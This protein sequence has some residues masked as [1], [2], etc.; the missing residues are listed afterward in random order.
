[1]RGNLRLSDLKNREYSSSRLMNVK[2]PAYV[3]D[4]IQRVAEQ[5]GA[6]KTEVVIA[7]LNQGLDASER[8]LKGWRPPKVTVSTAGR[9]CTIKGCG[10]TH[11]A[12]GYCATHYQAAKRGQLKPQA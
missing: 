9:R 12:K 1:M 8:A 11:V 6:S 3:S 7:L 2:V 5:L 4:A 10:Q